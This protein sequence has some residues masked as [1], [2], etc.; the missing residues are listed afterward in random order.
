MEDLHMFR[1]IIDIATIVILLAIIIGLP[2]YFRE[3]LSTLWNLLKEAKPLL[4]DAVT[5]LKEMLESLRAAA[6]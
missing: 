5:M 2:I 6:A 4:K 3:E 1:K